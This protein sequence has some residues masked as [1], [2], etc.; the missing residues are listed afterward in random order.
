MLKR[1]DFIE[2]LKEAVKEL[3]G[4]PEGHKAAALIQATVAHYEQF[5]ELTKPSDILVG[6]LLSALSQS[7]YEEK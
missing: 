2:L 6:L 4:F 7:S 1:E 3:E 5:P